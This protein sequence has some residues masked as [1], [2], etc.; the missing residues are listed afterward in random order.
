MSET[1]VRLAWVLCNPASQEGLGF[2]CVD[3]IRRPAWQGASHEHVVQ[4]DGDGAVLGYVRHPQAHD[5][6]NSD[7]FQ[8]V[9]TET[10]E[11]QLLRDI[12]DMPTVATIDV[13]QSL[14]LIRYLQT[15]PG[16]DLHSAIIVAVAHAILDGLEAGF[17][18][19]T[20]DGERKLF[21][22]IELPTGQ[23]RWELELF[24]EF[25]DGADA[26]EHAERMNAVITDYY[27]HPHEPGRCCAVHH[28]HVSPHSGCMLR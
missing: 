6:V 25:W 4:Q 15:I 16:E 10:A 11:E 18:C 13:V 8:T 21:A 28:V 27:G 1:A 2:D 23:V 7:Y 26:A 12:T 19:P 20:I 3:L 9:S 14:E 5:A 17:N 22:Y 24:G